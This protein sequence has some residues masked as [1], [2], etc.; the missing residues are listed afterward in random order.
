M[1][2]LAS[3]RPVILAQRLTLD[4]PERPLPSQQRAITEAAARAKAKEVEIGATSK[5]M[6]ISRDQGSLTVDVVD[7]Q[8]TLIML[9]M[10]LQHPRLPRV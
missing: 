2:S 4:N 8:V 7:Q 3:T 10:R 5:C 1:A 9:A 6:I